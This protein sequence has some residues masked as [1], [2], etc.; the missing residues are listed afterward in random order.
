MISFAA[1]NDIPGLRHA[2]LT[3]EG[4]VS[5]GIYT[6]LNC[7]LGSRDD[8][9]KVR[10]NRARA[11][12]M[13]DQPADALVTLYQAHTAEAV[14]VD[15]PFAPGA[16]PKADGMATTRPGLV[17]GILTA[18]CAPVLLADAKGGVIGAAHAGWRGALTGVIENTVAA[19]TELGAEPRRIVAAIGP[20]IAQRSY[21]VGPDFPAAFL[22]QDP[23]N[24][25]FFAP[26]RKDG[27]Y[28]FD[29]P[30]YVA[31]RLR[32]A[33]IGTVLPSPADTCKEEAR[34]FSYRRATLRG[35]ADYGR[36]L[37][38]IVREE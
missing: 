24:E 23:M 31:L 37:S 14:V 30:G 28:M 3:R 25:T 13:I 11:L 36:E 7:G 4:G 12:A 16:E 9:D 38:L 10:E 27:H 22:A 8:P 21:E 19:M 18:D 26:S 33:G 32:S 2:F 1:M 6:S 35:E 29:L 20:C 17:L 34:Y 5:D 15:A